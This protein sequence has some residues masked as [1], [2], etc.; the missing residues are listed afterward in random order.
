MPQTMSVVVVGPPNVRRIRDNLAHR[1]TE[2]IESDT[3]EPLD[4]RD[5]RLVCESVLRNICDE[6]VSDRVYFRSMDILHEIISLVHIDARNLRQFAYAAHMVASKIEPGG[7]PETA[8][9]IL[10]S[11]S[12]S[13]TEKRI[14]DREV[15]VLNALRFKVSG[16]TPYQFVEALAIL[17]NIGVLERIAVLD[18]LE[19]VCL[20]H[21][22]YMQ[23]PNSL[24][25]DSVTYAV[26]SSDDYRYVHPLD[27]VKELGKWIRD[28]FPKTSSGPVKCR[29]VTIQPWALDRTY[30]LGQKVGSGTFGDVY[31]AV[32][33]T[34]RTNRAIKILKADT[35]PDFIALGVN[36]S[37]I[38][39][40]SSLLLMPPHQNVVRIL[41]AH[42]GGDDPICIVYGHEETDL[43][44]YF[45]KAPSNAAENKTFITQILLGIDHIH[46]YG[47]LHGDLKPENILVSAER[48]IRVADL[49]ACGFISFT[50]RPG[51]QGSGCTAMYRSPEE[52]I[53]STLVRTQSSDDWAIGVIAFEI[54]T[55]A[56]FYRDVICRDALVKDDFLECPTSKSLMGGLFGPIILSDWPAAKRLKG[57]KSCFT[58]DSGA[59]RFPWGYTVADPTL[60][61]F[62]IRLFVFNPDH[63]MT[64]EEALNHPYIQ[65]VPELARNTIENRIND[66]I[67]KMPDV[68][69]SSPAKMAKM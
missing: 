20:N 41:E 32:N 58:V 14:R 55:R 9:R 6:D 36:E 30:V 3:F 63:R 1:E 52:F 68:F 60:F 66:R 7:V 16:P 34:D 15:E 27:E 18:K 59:D 21:S 24:I 51:P 19:T 61:D 48:K 2:K 8:E 64:T 50:G 45:R 44:T 53:G 11:A 28:H 37:A 40:I 42:G 26:L 65:H 69:R 43:R 57:F 62:I 54:A 33:R 25:A 35:D 12:A 23:H 47:F 5:V 29:R 13:Y 22:F 56:D 31:I 49:G 46:S 4:E 67:R 39:E 38:R 17:S 10:T